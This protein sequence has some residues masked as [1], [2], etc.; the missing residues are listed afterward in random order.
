MREQGPTLAQS[1]PWITRF[2]GQLVVVKLGGELLANPSVSQRLARQ[3]AVVAQCGIRPLVVHGAG[4]QV[5]AACRAR[6][7]EIKKIEGRR[8]TDPETLDVVTGVLRALNHEIVAH[9]REAG[10]NAA[11][12]DAL[13][14]WP[15][16]A[17]RRPPVPQPDGTT[18]DFGLVGDVANVLPLPEIAVNPAETTVPVLPCLGHDGQSWLNINADTLARSVAT[19]LTAVKIVFMTGVSGVMRQMDDAGPISQMDAQDVRDLLQS[20]SVTGGMRAKLQESLKALESGIP[21]VHII[22]GK[23]PHTLLRE[24]FTDEGCGTLILP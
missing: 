12:L 2:K 5:D 14:P 13:N 3:V 11:G 7:I 21:K 6:G 20:E 9:L 24:I 15:V 17:T 16:K 10:V 23:E 1:A 22:S 19:K 18:I 4:Q 8:V